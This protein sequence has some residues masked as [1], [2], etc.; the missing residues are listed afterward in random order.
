VENGITRAGQ[1]DFFVVPPDGT[2]EVADI[3]FDVSEPVPTA[4]TLSAPATQ[5]TAPGQTIQLTAFVQWPD[6][7]SRDVTFGMA[8][9]RYVSSN[10][11]IVSIANDGLITALSSGVALVSAS[12]EGTLGVLRVQVLLSGDS[13]GDG[14]P[15]DF[16]IANGLD[17]NNPL[18]VLD[19]PD[20]DGLSTRDEFDAGLLPF[21]PDTDDDRL[22]DGR[23]FEVGTNPL[24]FDTDG[25][26]LSDGLEI[27]T[28]SNP[29]DPNSYNLAQAL[30]RLE[31]SPAFAVITFDTLLGEA[32]QRLKVTGVL[33]D[34]NRLDLTSTS[35]GTGYSSSDLTICG[36]GSQSG[37]IFAGQPGSCIVTASNS[38]FSA[39]AQIE[40]RAF[41]PVALAVLPLP[42]HAN[43]V[44]VQGDFAYVAAGAA[45]L[46]VVDV[47]D[48]AH[49]AIA[50]QL[51]T[52]GNANDVKIAGDLALVAD[53]DA[54]LLVVDIADPRNPL[55][56]ATLDVPGVAY[57]VAVAGNVV[58]V[59]DGLGLRVMDIANPAQPRIVSSLALPG[60]ALG[61]EIDGLRALAVVA[62]GHA[63]L[64]VIGLTDLSAPRLLGS[65]DTGEAR[66]AVLASD[67]AFVADAEKG[68][69]AVD[70]SDLAAPRVRASVP[71]ET[72]GL[73][74]DVTL[75]ER[76][77]FGADFFF[78][79]GVPILDVSAPAAPVPRQILDFRSLADANGT[80]IAVD[81]NYVY[82]TAA[83]T[84]TDN[85]ATGN[86]VLLIGQ[87]LSITDSDEDGMPDD[88]EQTYGL[89]PQDP[90]D[91]PLDL[92]GDGLTN[93]QEF[94]AGSDPRRAD[95]D[96][97]GLT[98]GDEVERGTNPGDPDTDGDGLDDRAE[99]AR[100]TNPLDPDSDD[101]A[102]PDGIEVN[103]GLDP[104]RTDSDGDGL[105][106][107]QEDS[108]GDGLR[109]G[110]E[111]LRRTD[112]GNP[113][114]DGDGARD[115]LEVGLGCDPLRQD[116]TRVTGRVLR[117]PDDPFLDARVEVLGRPGL[118]DMSELDG[119]FDL[120][121]VP[122]C[123]R[124]I[125]AVATAEEGG[126]R[127]RGLSASVPA[128]LEG[129]TDAGDIVLAA[130][131]RPLYPTPY[132]PAGFTP[133]AVAAGDFDR[134]GV[135]DL[136]VADRDANRV[137]VFLGNGDA[138]FQPFV[139]YPVGIQ[140]VDVAVA[141]FNRDGAPDLVAANFGASG[142]DTVSVLLGNGDGTFRPEVR[143]PVGNG[144]QAVVAADIGGDG[145]PDILTV[146]VFTQTLSILSGRGD[147]TFSSGGSLI[148]G[149]G[150]S[151]LAV[152]DLLGDG[153]VDFI[154][155]NAGADD[156][157]V[158]F[159]ASGPAVRRRFPVGDAPQSVAVGDF[160][161]N[162]LLDIVTVNSGT[163]DASV[164]LADG[165]GG[166]RPQLRLP[167]GPTPRSVA[168]ADLNGDGTSDILAVQGELDGPSAVVV[169]LSNGD[170]T[171][172]P[173]RSFVGGDL[174]ESVAV[175]DLDADGVPDAVTANFISQDISIL[176]GEG[177][178]TFW[179][180]RAYAVGEGFQ[181][182]ASADLDG[183][184]DLDLIAAN[185]L[186]HDLSV[187]PGDGR[188][189][190]LPQSRLSTGSFPISVAS[191]DVNDDGAA[192]LAVAVSNGIS[193]HLGNGDLT[194][195]T[196]LQVPV[197]GSPMSISAVDFNRDGAAD[198][199][200][201]NE[202]SNDVAIFL[203]RGDGT[204]Q[205]E[206]RLPVGDAPVFARG[207]DV[208][209]DG[210][211]DV[212]ALNTVSNDV[213]ILLG[214]G[215]GTFGPSQ[216]FPVGTRPTWMATGD[217]NG[218]G[219]LDIV[220]GSGSSSS[221]TDLS[222][223][224]GNGDGTFQPERRIPLGRLSHFGRIA[225]LDGDGLADLLTG[226]ASG[227]SVL[228]A[229]ADGTYQPERRFVSGGFV[230]ETADLDG[231][232][233]PDVVVE[234]T[235]QDRIFILLHR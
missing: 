234:D 198:L 166:F 154:S 147:G 70:L 62:A 121:D 122:A 4:L 53:G 18:D 66:D 141:D 132:T 227:L 36:F 222:L 174:P 103:V 148:T 167:V 59:T 152:G 199:L 73:L 87:Y 48:R 111:V 23:E 231:N 202:S 33:I 184:G 93:V 94:L 203:S 84:L 92:D 137:S 56:L 194:F 68:F 99:L 128:V 207:A 217:L 165:S 185:S 34:G 214:N 229:R 47:S 98:D 191:G 24:L 161:R 85:A 113:D 75:R 38:G 143:Y 27:A 31:I 209:G 82:L 181:A 63:G 5:L 116:I 67:F 233:G 188:G 220:S 170:G 139:Q 230:L 219:D 126:T 64:H 65:V 177:D 42:G 196:P 13:D 157:S 91:G 224:L 112:P 7:S 155:A 168:A 221:N 20:N 86:T 80:G 19:D 32:S 107:A 50:A 189:G 150:P 78:F 61:V 117:G 153:V 179:A 25:D 200:T 162:G 182:A 26:G 120:L 72:G 192:D 118:S 186:S 235:T 123:P 74:A 3:R 49:P 129:T 151:D 225:D 156:V 232:G 206:R 173:G 172:Q 83:A 228:L 133:I 37:E 43:A 171:F 51:D 159:R 1:S 135:N 145:I 57:D 58:L 105:S 208:N 216:R 29:L 160:D 212:L 226:T 114:T 46:V 205:P 101:D 15:D 97:D 169:I 28:G 30:Q 17:P 142:N 81:G 183:D 39:Q 211:P 146:D 140:P 100:G 96:G 10:P 102:L 134:D 187:L 71:R 88:F 109:N 201:A 12:N 190:L 44:D 52:A 210:S 136:A 144:P 90:T 76:F 223:L 11:A 175:A 115:G 9:T 89:N 204:L 149:S 127:L 110:E 195:Q 14:L 197:T 104:L 108:D 125:R 164:L 215:D 106:D 213:A 79:N 35:R 8:G 178:G 45:G 163:G 124:T 40:V 193:L 138:T 60:T 41:S 130:I 2:I 21:D 54:G 6:G 95:T 77:A 176:L 22:L 119:R 158:F 180:R 131:A 16:E 69:T 218:D 55:L